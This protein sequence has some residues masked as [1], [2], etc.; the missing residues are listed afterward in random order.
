MSLGDAFKSDVKF[1]LQDVFDAQFPPLREFVSRAVLD[2]RI[3]KIFAAAIMKEDV[4][5]RTWDL[6]IS[7]PRFKVQV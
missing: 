7:E 1:A 5:G 3:E 2:A 4:F 6:D